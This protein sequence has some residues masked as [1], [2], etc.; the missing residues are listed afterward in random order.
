[1]N[2]VEIKNLNFSYHS[3]DVQVS[4]FKDFNLEIKKGDFIAIKGPSGSGKSTLLYLIAGLLNFQKGIIRFKKSDISKLSDYERSVLRNKYLSFIFQQFHLLPKATVLENILLPTFYPIE[5]ATTEEDQTEK[6]KKISTRLGI[7]ERLHHF[8]K[9]LSGGQQQRVAI[10]RA[11][12]HNPELILADEP[13]GNLDSESTQEI[14]S[15]LKEL[16]AEGK[17]IIL[18]THEEDVAQ[19]AKTIY[20][21]KDGKL[22]LERSN[23]T[24]STDDQE[25]SSLSIKTVAT[26]S[27]S[28]LKMLPLVI[29]NAFR[30]KFRSILTMLG[31][32]VGVAAVCSMVTLGNYIREKVIDGYSEMGVDTL[33]FRGRPNWEL[34]ATDR[35]PV[36]FQFFDWK[37]DILPLLTIFPQTQSFS[38][39]LFGWDAQVTY[40]GKSIENEA[41]LSGVSS[42][43]FKMANRTFL[44]GK[45][46]HPNH[47]KRKSPVCVIGHDIAQL[48]FARIRPLGQI[49]HISIRESTFVCQVIG[50]LNPVKNNPEWQK[51]NMQVIV[52]FTFFQAV[53][54]SWWQTQIQRFSI[55]LKPRNDIEGFSNAIK[56]F[57]E[58]K[59]GKSG[60]FSVNSNTLLL[61][62]MKKFLTLFSILITA[63]AL[64][65]L[66]VGGIGITNM[67][68]VSVSE[69]LKEIGIRKSVGA[70]HQSIRYQFLF[71]SVFLCLIA[72]VAGIIVGFLTYEG[73]LWGASQL[74]SKVTFEWI[75][76]G[77]AITLAFVSILMV[78]IL[79]GL[80]PAYKAEK[81]Q[82]IDAL[83]SE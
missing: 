1:M 67:M 5:N 75:I 18:I 81:L 56:T 76:D 60:R 19:S 68:L 78:G 13:T 9:Q 34:K 59:Y 31:I 66:T 69:R 80:I 47:I 70:T 37:R 25:I 26:S 54:D 36:R 17:T 39:I 29:K 3:G 44:S 41:L 38:P 58:K 10:A 71:E 8:P 42:T 51:A 49:I 14:I 12:I 52:P 77:Y 4:I 6:A 23:F 48:L 7:A 21:L 30:N 16:N 40:G 62:Q 43:W 28:Y 82:V 24:P 35:F 45:G 73:A 22:E 27:T 63:I 64:V 15:I 11:L 57:F 83:R 65:T 79:S 20:F 50:V 61:E 72:G 74:S 32:T 33:V 53:N 46:F 2:L 55:Q